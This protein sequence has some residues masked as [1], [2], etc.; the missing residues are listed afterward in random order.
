MGRELQLTLQ[1]AYR[2][3]LARRHAD[4]TVEHLLYALLHDTRGVEVLRHCGA[5]VPALK[6][7][8]QRFF[9]EELETLPEGEE[10]TRQTLAFHRVLQHA[11]HHA[12]SAEKDEIEAGDLLAAIFQEPDSHA[13]ALLRQQSVSRIDVLRYISHG[14]SKLGA[15]GGPGYPRAEA[16]EGGGAATPAGRPG[17][18]GDELEMPDDPL[19]AFATNLSERAAA[20]RLD[21]LVGREAELERAIH[22]LARR[23]KNNPIFVGETGVGKTAIAEGLAQRIQE[24]Q[25]PEDLRGA[26]VFS[27]DLGALLA[28]TRYRGDFEARF[29]A[30]VHALQQRPKPI[31]FIDEIHTILGAGAASGGTVDASNLLKPL[32]AAGELRCMGSTTYREYRHF[33]RDR[34]LAR[35]FQRI[36]VTEP[37]IPDAIRILQGLAPRYEEHH[38]VRYT[39]GALRAAVEL[40]ARHLNDHFLPDKAIDVMDEAGA[41]VRLRKR[42]KAARSEPKASEVHQDPVARRTVGVRDV[43]QVIARIARIPLARAAASDRARLANLEADLRKVVFAQDEAVATVARAVRRAHAG[44]SGRTRPIGSFLFMGPTGVGKTELAKQLAHTLGVPFL[45]FDMSEYMEKHAVARL[46]GAPPGYVGY[47]EGGQLV[48]RIRKHPYAVLLLDEI[49][50]A[51]P[52][53]FDILLQVMDH[54]TLT[55]NHGREADFRHVTLIMTSNVGARE[56]QARA[57][58]FGGEK[59]GDGRKDLERLFSPEFRNRLDEVVSF[60]ALDPA[61]MVRVVDKFVAELSAQLLEKRVRIEL[62]ADARAWLAEKGY[63]PDFGARPMARVVE[64]ELK[65]PIAEAVLFGPLARGGTARVSL[66]PGGALAFAFEGRGAAPAGGADTDPDEDEAPGPA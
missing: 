44:L 38:G 28:G 9:D 14:I 58:G 31:L 61:V 13:V 41:A 2:E 47:D 30:L 16:P 22:V 35:R 42:P 56:I 45:R 1:A 29:K 50:K 32:L 5:D 59:R 25:V 26:E 3:A 46:I 37:S 36:D 18:S 10:G 43:E 65:D 57:I 4:L 6:R 55:D 52:D 51:H 34:A 63:D 39:A 8:L 54:A 19:A 49:E 60:R 15:G 21:P 7:A 17:G 53:L 20:G 64:R 27:L 48:E 40:S 62:G 11:L 23:R 12:E 24:G 33:D 66:G